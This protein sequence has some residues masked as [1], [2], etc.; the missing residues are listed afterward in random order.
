MK[1]IISSLFI[2]LSFIVV[3]CDGDSLAWESN[4]PEIRLVIINE[5]ELLEKSI[6]DDIDIELGLEV[7][8]MPDIMS[9]DFEV[10]FDPSIFTPAS[11]D[12]EIFPSF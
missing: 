5:D 11:A 8:N 3:S 6:G 9:L 12:F 1:K 10:I 2:L 7:S 4:P